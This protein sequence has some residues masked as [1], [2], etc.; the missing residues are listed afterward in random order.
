M[1][2]PIHSV[3]PRRDALLAMSDDVAL[4]WYRVDYARQLEVPVE[5]LTWPDGNGKLP[6]TDKSTALR[7]SLGNR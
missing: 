5:D 1:F 6:M 4:A 3:W 2:S 7:L